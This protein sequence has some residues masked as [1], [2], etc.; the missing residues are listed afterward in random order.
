M[1]INNFLLQKKVVDKIARKTVCG[2][3]PWVG[4][5]FYDCYLVQEKTGNA[6]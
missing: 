5:P 1:E 4:N 2:M 3:E 6:Y